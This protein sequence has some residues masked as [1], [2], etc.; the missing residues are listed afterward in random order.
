MSR[1]LLIL[2]AVALV[3]ILIMQ[4]LFLY[5]LAY[6]RGRRQGWADMR[7]DIFT[8]QKSKP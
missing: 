7:P 3:L 8:S 2:K 4:I 6:N 1:R 5:D